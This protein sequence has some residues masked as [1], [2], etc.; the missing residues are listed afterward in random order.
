[1][2]KVS[3]KVLK[4]LPKDFQKSI[5]LDKVEIC[6]YGKMGMKFTNIIMTRSHLRLLRLKDCIVSNCKITQSVISDDSYL[7]HAKFENVDFT[8][9]IFRDTNLE[10][11]EFLNCDLRYVRFE[12]CL[13]NSDS[14]IKNSLPQE[15]NLK[16]GLL[17]QLYKNE[18][19]NGNSEKADK[20]LYLI[21][22]TERKESWDILTSKNSYFREKRQ[23][24]VRKYL[25]KYLRDSFDKYI[26]GYG[27]NLGNIIKT[28]FIVMTLFAI[29]YFFF[30]FSGVQDVVVRI[31]ES[32]LMSANAF[33]MGN[34]KVGEEEIEKS[35]LIQ[36]IVLLQNSVGILYIALITSA[37]YRRIAR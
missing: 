21:R 10:K 4:R 14:I 33:L 13:L 8:G 35:V 20:I 15:S 6:D 34:L 16:L 22:E 7:R 2:K 5:E 19:S 12:N 23:N 3:K 29:V 18:I 17:N 9:T 11:A 31:K 32:I 36:S 25:L 27:L 30:A 28:M 24:K 1:M 26:W 37:M